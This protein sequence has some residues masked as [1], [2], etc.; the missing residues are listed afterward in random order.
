MNVDQFFS[1][2]FLQHKL[3]VLNS[4]LLF[5]IFYTYTIDNRR[6]TAIIY[7]NEELQNDDTKLFAL[8]LNTELH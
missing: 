3:I 7:I 1:S 8:Q 5:P 2:D 4:F 6:K